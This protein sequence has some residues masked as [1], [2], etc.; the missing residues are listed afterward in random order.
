MLYEGIRKSAL[1]IFI[2]VALA[3]FAAAGASAQSNGREATE[4]ERELGEIISR[5][6]VKMQ[7]EP[8]QEVV[9]MAED[10]LTGFIRKYKGQD[11]EAQAR[12]T[13]GQVY[14]A[15]GHNEK[16]IDQYELALE[17]AGSMDARTR[18]LLMFYL[19]SSYVQN[20]KFDKAEQLYGRI[21]KE[22]PSENSKIRQAV[23]QE[24]KSLETKKKLTSGCQAIPFPESV[25]NLSGDKIAIRNYRGKV[26][27]LDFW[28]TWCKPCLDE[29]PNVKEL[30]E[31]YHDDGFEIIGVSLDRSKENL[32]SYVDENGIGWP[33]IYDGQGGRIATSYAVSA[34]PSTFLLDREGRIVDRNLRGKALEEAVERLL[35]KD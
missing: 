3:A 34:I 26:I 30:Y 4:A 17:A 13:L 33:Q 24:M 1:S 23:Q 35:K 19:A 29:M 18:A 9:R 21:L 14:T 20:E 10:Q 6:K 16:A 11:E 5:L 27:L 8:P 25:R 32:V 28:A 15:M 31:E 22:T 2:L 12:I 7:T